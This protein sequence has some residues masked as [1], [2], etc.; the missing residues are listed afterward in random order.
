MHVQ[1]YDKEEDEETPIL[2][3]MAVGV[4]EAKP[5]AAH[6]EQ[7]GDYISVCKRSIANCDI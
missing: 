1:E 2:N 4:A 5:A 7:I 3:L 6:S